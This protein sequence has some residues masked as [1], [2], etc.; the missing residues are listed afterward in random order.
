[1]QVP[2][3][4]RAPRELPAAEMR[5]RWRRRSTRG[6]R[7]DIAER[8]KAEPRTRSA[9]GGPAG[10]WQRRMRRKGRLPPGR[11]RAS[12][13]RAPLLLTVE[14]GGRFHSNRNSRMDEDRNACSH[15][16]ATD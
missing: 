8:A 10:G 2:R 13:R 11:R 4:R 3:S 9:D 5:K 15:S 12:N 7:G 14:I 16:A 1:V 6:G